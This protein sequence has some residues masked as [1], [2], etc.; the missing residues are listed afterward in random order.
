MKLLLLSDLQGVM[1]EDWINFLNLDDSNIDAIVTL[2]DIDTLELKS[3]KSRFTNK[4]I[5]GVLG[6]HDYDGDL[7]YCGITNLHNATLT[8]ANKRFVGIEGCVK[9][10]KVKGNPLYTQSEMGE[11]CNQLPVSDIV[12]SHNS[13]KGIHDKLDEAHEGFVGLTNYIDEHQPTHVFH[14]HQHKHQIS[15]HGNTKVVCIYGGWVWDQERDTFE[16]VLHLD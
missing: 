7:E 16:E 1:Y 5:F 12:I 8:V 13:P 3:I 10:K 4:L 15:T 6:N 14:G 9:Y 2:G 11:I